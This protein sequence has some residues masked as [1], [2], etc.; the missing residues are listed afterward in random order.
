M[1][2]LGINPGHNGTAALLKDGKIISDKLINH[3]R[4]AKDGLKKWYGNKRFNKNFAHCLK[5]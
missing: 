5:S 3:R 2:I 4:L 1:Y